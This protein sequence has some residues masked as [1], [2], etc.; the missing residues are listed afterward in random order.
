MQHCCITCLSCW[1]PVDTTGWL[2]FSQRQH[3]ISIGNFRHGP[4]WDAVLYLKQTLWPLIRKQLPAAELHIYGAYP[5]P[6][7]TALHNARQGFLVKGWA[8]EARAVMGAARICL[9]PL[10]FGAGLK[11]KLVEAMACGTPSVTTS[12]GAEAM[13]DGLPWNGAIENEPDAFAKAAVTLYQHEDRWRQCQ[14]CGEK[15]VETHYDRSE[16]EQGFSKEAV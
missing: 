13:H 1:K 11:G 3:F 14:Q 16:H 7:A 12:I 15:I 9:A 4:N 6:K 5:P 10:R 8:E 2:P